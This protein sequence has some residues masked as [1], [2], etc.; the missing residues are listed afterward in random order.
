MRIKLLKLYDDDK[1]AKK[2]RLKELLKSW[3]D[4]KWVFYYQGLPYILKVICLKLIN[5]HYEDPLTCHFDI[6]KTY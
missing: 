3:K 6:E 5:R 1:K 2:L 4:A